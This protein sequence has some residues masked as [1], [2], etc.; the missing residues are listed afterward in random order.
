MAIRPDTSTAIAELERR[1]LD[2]LEATYRD[3]GYE[4]HRGE[5]T[6]AVVPERLRV[7]LPDAVAIGANG[8][9]VIQILGSSRPRG[10]ERVQGIRELLRE[11]AGWKLNVVHVDRV[12]SEKW[13]A[14]ERGDAMSLA[15]EARAL[16]DEHPRAA[17]LLYWSAL[18]G[19]L[20]EL[21]P[22]LARPSMTPIQ[23]IDVLDSYDYIN[24]SERSDLERAA[25]LR[26]ALA[27]GDS[28][29]VE[30]G[31]LDT[32]ASVVNRLAEMGGGSAL[33]GEPVRR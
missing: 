16:G 17:L 4:F 1:A 5:A 25:M 22:P 28:V 20:R 31:T 12:E 26:N 23:L 21:E 9:E 3:R 13:R 27:H 29:A 2:R 18:E 30:D 33:G 11:E 6:R 24:S 14:A 15:L 19:L 8:K 7:A 10:A 32:V